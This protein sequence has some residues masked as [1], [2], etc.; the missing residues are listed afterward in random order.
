MATVIVAGG[1]GYIGSHTVRELQ[2]AGFKPAVVD[3]LV[4]GHRKIVEDV[5]R[6]PLVIGQVGDKQLLQ[7]LFSGDHPST[8]GKDI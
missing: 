8:R 2:N 3:N 6:V 5:L 4:Y 1:A 7:K